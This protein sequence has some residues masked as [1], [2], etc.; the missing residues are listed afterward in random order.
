MATRK[1]RGTA[2]AV[3]GDYFA[4]ACPLRELNRQGLKLDRDAHGNHTFGPRPDVRR[5]DL[6]VTS[7]EK[8]SHLPAGL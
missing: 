1:F 2:A 8:T 3:R 7:C 4:V 6:A 5:H